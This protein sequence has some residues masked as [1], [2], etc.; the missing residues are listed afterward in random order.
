MRASGS[1]TAPYLDGLPPSRSSSS[2]VTAFAA[3]AAAAVAP[4]GSGASSLRSFS[5]PRVGDKSFSRKMYGALLRSMGS[6]SACTLTV[7]TG[8][9]GW[10]VVGASDGWRT[11]AGG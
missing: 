5:T 4:G 9:G 11:F 3:A 10:P 6:V 7:D 8:Q 1:A 2:S